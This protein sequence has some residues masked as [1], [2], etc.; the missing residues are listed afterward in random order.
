MVKPQNQIDHIAVNGK[1][2]RFL[3]DVRVYRGADVNSD[4]HL[5]VAKIKLKLRKVFNIK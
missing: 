5:L 1:W 4:H 2:R 3:Q